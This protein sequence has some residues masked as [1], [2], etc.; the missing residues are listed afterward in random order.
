MMG[1]PLI[2]PK[3]MRNF[4]PDEYSQYVTNMYSIRVKGGAKPKS[5]VEGISV[6]RNKKGALA[7]YRSKA[8]AFAYVTQEEV[9]K[10]A[11]AFKVTQAEIWNLF[12]SKDYIIAKDRLEA[13]ATYAA[14]QEIPWP[15]TKQKGKRRGNKKRNT[16]EGN[17]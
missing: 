17:R 3:P 5:P 16:K 12:K 13:E 11:I 10:L 15:E 1:L 2:A 8:R 4:T 7:I 6:R 9:V 14:I